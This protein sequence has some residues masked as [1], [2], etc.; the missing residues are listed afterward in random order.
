M[1]FPGIDFDLLLEHDNAGVGTEDAGDF[2]GLESQEQQI[3]GA[4][5]LVTEDVHAQNLQLDSKYR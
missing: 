4:D 5:Q 3:L 2:I 1:E